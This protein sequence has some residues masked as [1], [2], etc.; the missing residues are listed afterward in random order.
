MQA[1]PPAAEIPIKSER[2]AIGESTARIVR[3]MK[4]L[5]GL[6]GLGVDSAEVRRLR[7]DFQKHV[8]DV[9]AQLGQQLG[10]LKDQAQLAQVA[11]ARAEGVREV[12][13]QLRAQLESQLGAAQERLKALE[14]A[15]APLLDAAKSGGSPL[16]GP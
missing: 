14:G 12:E 4:Q 5:K 7:D 16:G 13:Q 10:A 8:V 1:C 2:I 3:A 11:L 6:G 9:Q 15:T